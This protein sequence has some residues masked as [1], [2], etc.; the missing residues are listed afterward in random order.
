MRCILSS[1][2]LAVSILSCQNKN[3]AAEGKIISTQ[4]MQQVLWDMFQ[5][6]A[7]TDHYLKVD[8]TKNVAV[9]NASLQQKIFDLHKINKADFYRSYNYY[10]ARPDIMRPMLDSITARAERERSK[11]MQERYSGSHAQ[12]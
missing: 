12:Y 3:Q 2:F 6:E 7:F 11:V 4:I 8:T 9:E 10:I 1:F 5:A